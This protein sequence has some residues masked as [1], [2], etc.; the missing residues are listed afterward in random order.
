M[1]KL[2]LFLAFAII[3]FSSH[4]SEFYGGPKLSLGYQTVTFEG[5]NWSVN[6]SGISAGLGMVGGYNL[7][8]QGLPVRLEADFSLFTHVK[9]K[10]LEV[11]VNTLFFSA[12]YDLK[13]IE[14]PESMVPYVGLGVGYYWGESNVDN[15]YHNA[16]S[17]FAFTL[18]AGVT[19]PINNDMALDVGYRLVYL[20]DMYFAG[21]TSAGYQHNIVAVLRLFF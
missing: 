19:Y 10:S 18:G 16:Y 15:S 7:E 5:H 11:D 14:L 1:K 9:D 17:D 6:P 21:D 20:N 4:A 8:T 2:I 12:F 13:T 3:P